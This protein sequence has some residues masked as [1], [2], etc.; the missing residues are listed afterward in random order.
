MILNKSEI[1]KLVEFCIL[2]QTKDGIL[3]KAPSYINEKWLLRREDGLVLSSKNKAIFDQ[4]RRLWLKEALN[5][6]DTTTRTDAS[7]DVG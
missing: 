2:M 1:L 3:G 5:D 4:W 6:I 7:S